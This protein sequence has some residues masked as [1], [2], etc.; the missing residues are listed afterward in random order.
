MAADDKVGKHYFH[1]LIS[2]WHALKHSVVDK[3][4]I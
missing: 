1:R 4:I 3:A 2:F